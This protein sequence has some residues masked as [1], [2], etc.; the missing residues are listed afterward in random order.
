MSGRLRGFTLIELVMSQ[1]RCRT[2]AA[3]YGLHLCG[4]RLRLQ[5]YIPRQRHG[6]QDGDDAD[7]HDQFD[8]GE[9]S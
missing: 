7:R 3:V 9:T 1:H 2:N 6:R 5:R 4:P 8:Q